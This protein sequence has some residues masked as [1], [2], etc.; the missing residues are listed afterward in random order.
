MSILEFFVM[1]ALYIAGTL[2]SLILTGFLVNKFVIKKIVANKDVQD[3]LKLFRE[4]KEIL[5]KIL[6]E[7]KRVS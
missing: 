2:I 7:K 5:N 3:L 1:L 4:G 6:E